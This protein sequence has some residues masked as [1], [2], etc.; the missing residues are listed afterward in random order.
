MNSPGCITLLRH[1]SICPWTVKLLLCAG[2]LLSPIPATA[3]PPSPLCPALPYP[4]VWT[5]TFCISTLPQ[6]SHYQLCHSLAVYHHCS[7]FT[8]LS[9]CHKCNSSI[10]CFFKVC[11]TPVAPP[12]MGRPALSFLE[13]AGYITHSSPSNFVQ[14]ASICPFQLLFPLEFLRERH[15]KIFTTLLT[16]PKVNLS[17]WLVTIYHGPQMALLSVAGKHSLLPLVRFP[18]SHTFTQQ[19]KSTH[20]C[21]LL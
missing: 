20:N 1:S 4:L 9:T 17:W 12:E 5:S 10:Y 15:W 7:A 11:P 6:G 3:H 2:S 13:L 8:A 18:L 19:L 16:L 21:C 14:R